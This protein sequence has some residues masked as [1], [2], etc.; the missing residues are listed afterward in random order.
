ML[1]KN[2]QYGSK[3]E[4]S[5]ARS[6]KINIAPQNGTNNYG[7]GDTIIFNIPTRNNLVMVPTESY[8]KFT[9]NPIVS[10]A[11]SSAFRLDSCGIHGVIQR[12]RV[13]HGSNLLQDIDNYGLLAKMLM[14]IQVSTDA[15]YGKNNILLGTRNDM[16][17]TVGAARPT[18]VL[19][20]NSGESIRNS[21]G[22]A[23][24]ASTNT[25]ISCSYAVNLISL[26]GSLCSQ[27]YL[28]LFCM[29]SSTLRV[30][31]SLVDSFTKFLNVVG[32]VPTLTNA[33]LHR[34]GRPSY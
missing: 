33:E 18:S 7:L 11:D 21:T 30:E 6:S 3:V 16:V 5:V 8:L 19:Q 32:G 22:S 29:K 26:V 1:P 14:D 2:L 25:S 23:V 24:F 9:L 10:S 13:W 27:Q 20:V 4:S 12:I 28:P 31:I 15:S 34:I 17:C